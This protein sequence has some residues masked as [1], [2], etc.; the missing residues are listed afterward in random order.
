MAFKNQDASRPPH[1]PVQLRCLPL[2]PA[3]QEG[4][5]SCTGAS[6]RLSSPPERCSARDVLRHLLGKLA[7][8]RSFQVRLRHH[9][10][11]LAGAVPSREL[12]ANVVWHFSWVRQ[13]LCQAHLPH[14]SETPGGTGR[15]CLAHLCSPPPPSNLVPG[16]ASD[17]DGVW[18]EEG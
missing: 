17:T 4:A 16:A 7:S 2:S 11:L 5:S 9:L 18:G 1:L 12:H 8:C 6:L 15:A 13:S 14:R 10:P 3:G